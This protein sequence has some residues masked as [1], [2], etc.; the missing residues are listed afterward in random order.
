MATLGANA[1]GAAGALALVG[2][3]RAAAS[4]SAALAL[5]GT[6]GALG[7]L[8]AAGSER[9]E[10]RHKLW[11]STYETSFLMASMIDLLLGVCS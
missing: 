5:G 11:Q 4:L 8:A 2:L 1:A 6:A 9:E 3:A 10:P 7:A